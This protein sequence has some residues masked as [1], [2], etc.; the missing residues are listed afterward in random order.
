M[1]KLDITNIMEKHPP[2]WE[3]SRYGDYFHLLDG[4][5]VVIMGFNNNEEELCDL[6]VTAVNLMVNSFQ[7]PTD[8]A[9]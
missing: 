2:K 7:E 8:E 3:K 5:D 6:I 1:S 9:D 4:N